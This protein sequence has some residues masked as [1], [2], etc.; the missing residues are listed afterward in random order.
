MDELTP[1]EPDPYAGLVHE[2][3]GPVTSIQS[4]V[5]MLMSRDADLSPTARATIHQVILQQSQ[6]LDGFV[7]DMVL[8]VRLLAH[9][10]DLHPE[11]VLLSAL[12]EEVRHRLGEPARVIVGADTDVVLQ[13]DRDALAALLRRLI[14]NA[15]VYGPREASVRVTVAAEPGWNTIRVSDSGLGI[16]AGATE[17]A[18]QPFVRAVRPGERRSD[19]VGLGLA[20]SRELATLM[21]GSLELANTNPGLTAALRLPA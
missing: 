9:G 15:L 17:T 13:A 11:P 5:R 16:P 7:D 2:L 18:M 4:Y 8:Y 1:S 12:L 20:V 10:L 19:G 3:R 6:R 21:Q 14:R